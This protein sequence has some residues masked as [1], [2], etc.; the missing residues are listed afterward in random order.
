MIFK[1]D[2]SFSIANA[3][4]Y[5][6]QNPSTYIFNRSKI[7]YCFLLLSNFVK[8][9]IAN[10]LEK[11]FLR[12]ETF[13]IFI[14]TKLSKLLKCCQVYIKMI[15]WFFFLPFFKC[16]ICRTIWYIFQNWTIFVLKS[17]GTALTKHKQMI[18]TTQFNVFSP[19]WFLQTLEAAQ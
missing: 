3:T 9:I 10:R 6:C 17:L 19:K 11:L 2:K 1:K 14:I 15:K 5:N 7:T 18:W 13:S 16:H 8:N 12:N 4:N